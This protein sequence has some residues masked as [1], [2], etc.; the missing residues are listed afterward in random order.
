MTAGNIRIQHYPDRISADN[1]RVSI[2]NAGF[3]ADSIKATPD[4]Y[5]LIPTICKRPEDGG[6]PPKG[7]PC[8]LP[9]NERGMLSGSVQPYD[10]Y[11]ILFQTNKLY[12][13]IIQC[14]YRKRK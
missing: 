3:D 13:R 5:Q 12:T 4:S 7:V 10:K 1:L 11:L 6:G 8:K 9:P 14:E 2:A